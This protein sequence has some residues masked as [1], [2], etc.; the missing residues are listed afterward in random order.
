MTSDDRDSVFDT[1]HLIVLGQVRDAWAEADPVPPELVETIHFALELA[2]PDAEIMRA[3]EQHA[4]PA[5]KGDEN[6]R[7]ITFDGAETAV[8]INI[9]PVHEDAVRIDG[10]LTPPAAHRIV[11]RTTTGELTVSSDDDGR[12]AFLD[13]PRGMAQFV[14][15]TNGTVTTPAIV[16]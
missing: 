3:V 15:R 7:L 13:V 2:S 1:A 14:V 8:M 4:L 16:L 11:L 12:F 5:A 10:W 9:S 6:T